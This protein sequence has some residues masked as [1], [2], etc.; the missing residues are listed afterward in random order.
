MEVVG[1][2][3][4]SAAQTRALIQLERFTGDAGHALRTPLAAIKGSISFI[5]SRRKWND[6][7]RKPLDIIDRS[8]NRMARLIDDLLL[9]A[10]N[11]GGKQPYQF[12][13]Q[14]LAVSLDAAVEALPRPERGTLRLHVDADQQVFGDGNALSRVFANFLFNAYA[15]ARPQVSFSAEVDGESLIITVE[16]DGDGIDP[17]HIARLGERFYRPESSRSRETGGCG[18]GLAIVKSIAEAHRGSMKID[19]AVGVGT[20]VKVI[21]PNGD[22]TQKDA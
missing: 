7:I 19:S 15:Y 11:D 4:P 18:L 6:E 8:S 13:L 2:V 16:D 9:L 1:C 22:L 12:E 17:E 14:P 20:K 10:R 3:S 21:L 5:A